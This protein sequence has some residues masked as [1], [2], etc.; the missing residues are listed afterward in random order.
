MLYL[1]IYFHDSSPSWEIKAEGYQVSLLLPSFPGCLFFFFFLKE[2]GRGWT[3]NTTDI[4]TP[5]DAFTWIEKD[6]TTLVYV[7]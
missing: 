4:N 5:R 1:F 2:R 6:T 3:V 7:H